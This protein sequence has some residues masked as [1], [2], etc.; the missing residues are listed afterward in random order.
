LGH[1]PHEPAY[2]VRQNPL[3]VRVGRAPG[4]TENWSETRAR[5]LAVKEKTP[6]DGVL[7]I[8][9]TALEREWSVAGRL[10]GFIKAERYF[11]S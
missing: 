9:E 1:R 3:L 5:I 4:L 7:V 2:G 8:G 6:A 10:A 11:E